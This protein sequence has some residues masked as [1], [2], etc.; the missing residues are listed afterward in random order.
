ML[1]LV[2]SKNI[3]TAVCTIYY[4]NFPDLQVQ[5]LSVA[6]LASFNDVIIRQAIL[7]DLPILDLRLI[8][9]EAT[10]YANPIEPSD[11]GGRKIARKIFELIGNHD[12]TSRKTQ[13]FA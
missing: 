4:P 3:P 11:T 9:N 6:A 8:C 12:F 2:L 5:K 7:N 10:D 13:I 1:K